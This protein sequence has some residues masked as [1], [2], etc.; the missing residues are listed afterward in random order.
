MIYWCWHACWI[1]NFGSK[2]R[3]FL[4]SVVPSHFHRVPF[5]VSHIGGACTFKFSFDSKYFIGPLLFPKLFPIKSRQWNH[6]DDRHNGNE[7]VPVTCSPF[8]HRTCYGF[9]FQLHKV[10][11]ILEPCKYHHFRKYVI[12]YIFLLW[13]C[14]LHK[15]VNL[16]IQFPK[17][18]LST[19]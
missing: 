5:Q 4:Y 14:M 13:I 1:E 15:F 17:F 19:H 10:S 7:T 3:V 11:V 8:K 9:Y 18:I 12:L 2:S 6:C 16:L